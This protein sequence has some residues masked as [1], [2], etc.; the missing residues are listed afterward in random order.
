MAMPR[1][2][3]GRSDQ[4]VATPR[5]FLDAVENRFGPIGL[6]L[7]AN[8]SNA[9]CK[10]WLGPGS[11]LQGGEDALAPAVSWSGRTLR[12]LNPPYS[13]LDPWAAK[14]AAERHHAF[15]AMLTPASVGAN[16]FAEHVHGKAL[17]LAI[18]PRLTFVGSSDPYP[19][20]LCLSVCGGGAND[21]ARPPPDRVAAQ[22]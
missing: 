21:G 7:A 18:R 14:C 6:D 4:V 13:D 16:W 15:I 5:N 19:K 17:V 20:D 10:L 9:V 11:P 12:W 8:E 2:K 3:P 22:R 1:Q